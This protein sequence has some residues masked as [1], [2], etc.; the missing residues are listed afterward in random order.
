MKK[1]A[2]VVRFLVTA[3]DLFFYWGFWVFSLFHFPGILFSK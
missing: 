1:E 2:L 3:E